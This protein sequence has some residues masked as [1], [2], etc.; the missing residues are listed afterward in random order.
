MRRFPLT[1]KGSYWVVSGR[2][3][4]LAVGVA[5]AAFI[6]YRAKAALP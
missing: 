3:L 1:G 6:F 5:R 2:G 4:F